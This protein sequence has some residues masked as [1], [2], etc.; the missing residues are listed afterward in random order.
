[1]VASAIMRR[2]DVEDVKWCCI[3]EYDVVENSD[4]VRKH[5]IDKLRATAQKIYLAA[6][7]RMIEMPEGFS[8]TVEYCAPLI[9]EG[10]VYCQDVVPKVNAIVAAY[11]LLRSYGF[12]GIIFCRVSL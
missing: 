12:Q 10:F 1:M 7:K 11:R 2:F 3:D 8:V 6:H 4:L 9:T 5:I